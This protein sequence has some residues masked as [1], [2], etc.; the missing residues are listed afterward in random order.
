MMF[1]VTDMYLRSKVPLLHTTGLSSKLKN[2]AKHRTGV[3]F[4]TS[5]AQLDCEEH[6]TEVIYSSSRVDYIQK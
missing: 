1:Q 5:G 3:A 2:I 6:S 4:Q